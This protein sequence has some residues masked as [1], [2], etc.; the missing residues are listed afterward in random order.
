MCVPGMEKRNGIGYRMRQRRSIADVNCQEN[1]LL[2]NG[3]ARANCE[4]KVS[5]VVTDRFM[6]SKGIL[7]VVQ[8]DW[9][10]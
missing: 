4:R 2:R 9:S 10:D 8:Q 3:H 7:L 1:K 5:C 6:E